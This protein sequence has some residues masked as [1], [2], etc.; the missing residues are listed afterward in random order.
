MNLSFGQ[1]LLI[2]FGFLLVL[3]VGSYAVTGDYRLTS[4]TSRYV[5]AMA[6]D[7][8][9]QA[10]ASIAEWLNTRLRMT[11]GVAK[12]LESAE[13]DE[14]ARAI[15]ES[16]NLGG[17]FKDV[18]VGRSDGYMLMR[19]RKAQQSLPA[20]YDPRTRPWFKLARELGHAS[21]TKPYLDAST[22]EIV[23]ST[24]A[25]VSSGEFQ[26]VAGGDITLNA[27]DQLLRE[28]NLAETG[29]AAL[30]DG[31]GTV[32]YHPET[33]LMGKPVADFLGQK[34]E[35][36]GP[37]R[38]IVIDDTPWRVSF[39]EIAQARGVDWQLV[40][41]ANKDLIN[42]PVRE[43]RTTGLLILVIG[44]VVVLLV[45]HLG[46]RVLMRPVYR[47]NSAMAD[48]AS[49]EA[50]LTRR[51]KVETRDEFGRLAGS[52][53]DF[54][55]NIQDVVRDAQHGTDELH[56]AVVSLRQTA[57]TSRNSVEGQQQEVDMIAT[58]INEMSA[59][60]SE[61]ARNAQQTAD[62]SQTADSEA[63]ETVDTVSQSREAVERLSAEIGGAAQVIERLGKDVN[64]I[65]TVLEVIEGVAEQTNLL[66]LNAA[67]EAARAGEA[68]RG[69]AVVADEVRNLAQ[70]TQQS[71]GEVGAVIE[72]LQSG[73]NEAVRVMEASTRVSSESTEKAQL[74]MDA[75]D[76]IASAITSINEMTS[77]IATAS[78]EQTSVSEELNSSITRIAEKGQEAAAASSDNDSHSNRIDSVAS[79][80][81]SKVKRFRV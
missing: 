41:F 42:A 25:P 13:N 52:F 61:I 45:L 59:A 39:H 9:S 58:A 77:Q 14:Q 1:K 38:T 51:L 22:G 53:N 11:E 32:L 50:D 62:A 78:E 66:A 69:F 44:L 17:G 73:A 68:G 6:E 76:R 80:L 49:G 79:E 48:I 18:Y 30:V 20:D 28:V 46:I 31:E 2:A 7:A 8:A 15:L 72:R 34:V 12:A 71:T 37:A 23:L 70:R 3:V 21:I 19:N 10:T 54:V 24:L 5:E 16:A 55:A 4:T 60:A 40:M 35:P 43:A 57:S 26:G 29:Y 47:L 74:A 81:N 67:I 63:R 64:E 33:E 75:L 36:E 27:V 65:T 56:E